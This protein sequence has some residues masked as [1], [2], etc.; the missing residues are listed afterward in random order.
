MEIGHRWWEQI[1][2]AEIDVNGI[3]VCEASKADEKDGGLHN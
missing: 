1:T 2:T 3:T